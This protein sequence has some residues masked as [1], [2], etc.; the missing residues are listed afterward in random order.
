MLSDDPVFRG[1]SLG[2]SHTGWVGGPLQVLKGSLLR[3]HFVH[4][5]H[6]CALPRIRRFSHRPSRGLSPAHPQSQ[7]HPGLPALTACPVACCTFHRHPLDRTLE[8][9][10]GPPPPTRPFCTPQPAP[11]FGGR[12]PCCTLSDPLG[13]PWQPRGGGASALLRNRRIGMDGCTV[14]D[15]LSDVRQFGVLLRTYSVP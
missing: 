11:L 15:I 13:W 1:S 6:H 9:L 4:Y 7:P 2:G 10:G 8:T 14:A 3:P 12:I 5:H